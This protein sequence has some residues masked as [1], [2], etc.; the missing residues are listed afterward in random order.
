[1]TPFLE[2]LGLTALHR[3]DPEQGHR[4]AIKALNIGAVPLAG[5]WAVLGLALGR[6]RRRREDGLGENT[7]D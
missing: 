4:L 1:M 6:A 5:L 3:I 7:T 2:R